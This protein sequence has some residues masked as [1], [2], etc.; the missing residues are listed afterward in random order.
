MRKR[1]LWLSFWLCAALVWTQA[2]S[3]LSAQESAAT[4]S[5]E[6]K[7]AK[8]TAFVNVNIIPMDRERVLKGQ[9]LIVREGKIAELGEAA[10][11]E[12]PQDALRIDGRGRYLIPGLMDMHTH[13]FSDDEFP[14]SL[15]GD[16]LAIML[17]NGVTTIRLMIGTPEHL[18]YRRKIAA[19]DMLGPTLYVAS[20]EFTGRRGNGVFN[21]RLVTTPDEARTAVRECKGLGYDFIKL[22]TFITRPVYDAVIETAREQGIRVVGHVD[23]EVG[24]QHAL[25]V[26]QQHIEHLDSYMEALLRDDAPMKVSVSDFGVWR[27]PNWESLD[28]VDESKIAALAQATAKTGNFTCPTLTFF[29]INFAVEQSDD[30]IRARPDFRFYP[31]N[32]QARLFAAHTRFWTNPPSAERRAK[33]QRVRN[34]LVKAIREAGGKV[35]AGSDTP[36]LFLVY[37][38]TLHRELQNLV[39]AGLSNYDALA[40]ATST[41]A[42]FLKAFDTF[43]SIELGK[44]ADLVLLTANPLDDIANTEKRAGVMVRGRW[45]SQAELQKQLDEIALRF[46]NT[47]S[48]Q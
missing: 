26:G 37:G 48:A 19:G 10:K 23:A 16:E 27:K 25:A 22:T 2:Q 15:A 32:L 43:G 12:I 11:I 9:T 13:L 8:V 29:K 35:M 47:S 46:Q 39:A 6:A 24:L 31:K 36:E 40:A 42:E 17:A 44:R 4:I 20:P 18:I 28:Y 33:Y 1:A 30:E 3:Y 45:L 38:F 41:P 5:A 21:G 34:Q 7:G 14:K